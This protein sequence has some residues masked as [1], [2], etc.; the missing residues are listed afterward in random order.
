MLVKSNAPERTR[1]DHFTI[2][3]F[4]ADAKI[5]EALEGAVGIRSSIISSTRLS[6]TPLMATSPKRIT[7]HSRH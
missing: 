2:G 7:G 4:H 5:H 3:A 1:L 6:P